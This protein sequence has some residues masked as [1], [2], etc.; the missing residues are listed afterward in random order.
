MLYLWDFNYNYKSSIII[1]R[2]K[3]EKKRDQN[4]YNE[5]SFQNKY[6]NYIDCCP[7]QNGG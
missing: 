7:G 6:Y 3:N 4:L 1:L 5:T 2:E